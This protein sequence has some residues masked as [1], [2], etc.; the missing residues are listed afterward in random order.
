MINILITIVSFVFVIFV[1]VSIHE[2]GHLVVAKM[3]GVYCYE[4]SIG[5]GP[6]LFKYQGKETKYTIRL[7]PL[8]GFVSMAGDDEV[9]DGPEVP[10]NRWLTSVNRFKRACIMIAG[11]VMNVLLAWIIFIS[12]FTMNGMNIAPKPVVA[13]VD[14]GSVAQLAGV[15]AGDEITSLTFA[16][17]QTVNLET[18]NDF[19][20]NLQL[21]QGEVTLHILRDEQNIDITLTPTY[22]EA[23]QM[24]I[25]GITRLPYEHVS[26]NFFEAVRAGFDYIAEIAG[27]MVMIIGLLIRGQGLNALSG[28]VGIIKETGQAAQSGIV[29]L[30]SLLGLLSLNVGLF[31]LLPL[32]VM[33]GGRILLLGI[34]SIIRRPLNKKLES[35]LMAGSM[36]LLLLLVLVVTFKDIMNIF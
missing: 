22:N 34:E 1:I 11:I 20:L 31:N 8:G 10:E 5:F 19:T 26:L 18:I 12:L 29:S 4:Y 6:V 17:G 13:T 32:P 36:A 15:E 7:L 23:Q 33:D 25:I 30:I 21:Y 2:L 9:K 16:S 3:C 35:A 14:P 27:Q 24:Y 28:P